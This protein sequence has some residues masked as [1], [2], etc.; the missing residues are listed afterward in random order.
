LL[1]FVLIRVHL[2]WTGRGAGPLSS[3]PL[4]VMT[5]HLGIPNASLQ[6][7]VLCHQ[8]RVP[9]VRQSHLSREQGGTLSWVSSLLKL[10]RFTHREWEGG[11]NGAK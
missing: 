4:E 1:Y 7:W 5:P 11:R 3:V 10:S 6:L 2:L 8:G 9:C